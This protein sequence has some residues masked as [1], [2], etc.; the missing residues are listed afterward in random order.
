[1]ASCHDVL[2]KKQNFTCKT[3]YLIVICPFLSLNQHAFFALSFSINITMSHVNFLSL[4]N[5]DTKQSKLQVS[6][7]LLI[8]VLK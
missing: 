7:I 5:D 1:M 3:F 8:F 4:Y 2:S 6:F